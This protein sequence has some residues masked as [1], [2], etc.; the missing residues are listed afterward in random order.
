MSS[1]DLYKSL[2]TI[3]QSIL[4]Q[5]GL[6]SVF[7]AI[8]KQ[9]CSFFNASASSIMLF[10]EKKEYLTITRSYNLSSEYLKVVKVRKDQE[11]AGK[12]CQ[13]RKPRFIKDIIGL[14]K[15]ISDDFTV[16]WA[17]REGLISLVCAPLLLKDEPIGCLNIYYR[18]MHEAFDNESALDFFTRM[19]ALA[20]E[21]SKTIDQSEEKTKILTVLEEV[22]LVLTSSFDINEIM[23]VF[24]PTAVLVTKADGGGIVLFDEKE[25]RVVDAFE[26]KKGSDIPRRYKTTI[27]LG[28]DISAQVFKTRK[29]A[30]APDSASDNTTHNAQPSVLAAMPLVAREKMVGILYIDTLPKKR[31]SKS[32]IDYLQILCSQAA[33]ALDNTR[34]YRRVSHEAKEMALLYEVS[35][36]FI[37]T[38]DFDQLLKNILERL[39]ETFGY[40][41]L[42]IML[43][44]EEKQELYPRSYIN[45]PDRIKTLRFKIGVDGITGHVAATRKMYYSP[46]VAKDPHYKIGVDDA[47]SEVCYPLMIGDR[48]IGVL[49]V[50]SY[51]INGFTQDDIDMLSGLSAQI[52]MA[53]ENSRL[54]EEAKRLSLTDPL[55]ILP[56]RRNLDI[57]LDAEIRRSVRYRRKFSILMID[58][59]NFKNYNDTF[60]HI[61]GDKILRKF[62]LLMKEAIR[63]VDFLGRYGGDEF[64]AVLPETD[65][66]FALEVAERMRKK[67]HAEETTPRITLSIGIASYP[68]DSKDKIQLLDIADQACYEAKQLGGN[69]VNFASSENE[70]STS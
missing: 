20:I 12:V 42:A 65:R 19:A 17:M 52:A 49:D 6:D 16:R 28:L 15:D 62:G 18:S 67:I 57:F 44:D 33:I 38:L 34:L 10:D 40:L 14:F 25:E 26:Y 4:E 9:A 69:C 37:S 55:T 47:R 30:I 32:E 41:N 31:I 70:H 50:E 58:F 24:L 60:G 43:V 7:D 59:D 46:D 21:Y 53:L 13:A 11:V 1:V 3:T 5:R 56:N 2:T 64:I 54:Y 29:P 39:K 48:L 66:T 45:Y 22:G 68:T 36:S 8:T 27:R 61:A 23:T 35:R 51:E 63:D